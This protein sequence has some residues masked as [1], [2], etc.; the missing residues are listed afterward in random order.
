MARGYPGAFGRKVNSWYVWLPL[1]LLFLAPFVPW[2]R[3]PTLLHL[4]LLVLLGFS[5]SLAFFNHA[6]IGISVPLAYP[7]L[8]YLLVR[9]LLLAFGRG[10]P[11]EPLRLLVPVPWLAVAIVFLVGFRIGLNVTDSNVIDV[12]YAGVI[13][14]D[15]LVHGQAALRPL[16][17]E[18]PQRRHL[19]PGQL[20]RLCPGAG[21]LRL[22]RRLGRP[23]GRPCRGARLRSAHPGR[24]V[25]ARAPRPRAD[26][27]H[28]PGLRLGG[29]P[30]HPLR[31][32]LKQQRL[33]GGAAD[34]AD[35]AGPSAPRRPAGW[36][37]RWPA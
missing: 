27:R 12:G 2:R 25:P 11:R 33:A 18:Q 36:P 8:L 23:P 16:P 37:P 13:G 20:L 14:A 3:R 10:R 7:F 9:M 17:L 15:K 28:R 30:V 26:H 6:L 35:V 5:V 31:A 34:R 1:C 24:P 22:E 4:D 32:Q 21:D 29:L 19:R